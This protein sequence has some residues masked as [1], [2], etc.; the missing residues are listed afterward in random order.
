[1][2]END[3]NRPTIIIACSEEHL[4]RILAHTLRGLGCG[5]EC[6]VSHKALVARCMHRH[7]ALILTAFCAPLLAG[8]RAASRLSGGSSRKS[9]LFVIAENP[10]SSE[11]VALLE[12]GVEQVVTLPISTTRLRSKIQHSLSPK[13]RL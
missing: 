10:S 5:V 6:V 8:Y 7:Y 11:V 2:R 4:R 13:V 9:S 12:R 1:M 3:N